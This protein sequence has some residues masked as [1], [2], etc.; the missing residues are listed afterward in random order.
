LSFVR[1]H[2]G[3]RLLCSF[4]FSAEPAELTLPEGVRLA[5]LAGET[6]ADG[7]APQPSGLTGASVSAGKIHFQPWGGLIAALA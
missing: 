6:A 1:E 2:G 3:E 7:A 5:G 4:N